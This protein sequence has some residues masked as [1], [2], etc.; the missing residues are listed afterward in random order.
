MTVST[1]ERDL[2]K[3]AIAIQ[4]LE[5]GRS[6]AAGVC[7]LAASVAST[8]VKAP[9]CAATTKVLLFPRSANAATELG[10]GTL[11]V[12]AVANGSFTLTHASNGQTDRIFHFVCLG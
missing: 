10:N 1:N 9:N 3:F 2:A 11:Y 7:T 5:Q 8:T 12:S 4:Q 6:N